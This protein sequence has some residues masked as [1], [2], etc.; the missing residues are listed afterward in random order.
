MSE[1]PFV[2]LIEAQLDPEAVRRLP[3]F[4]L[5]LTHGTR[6]VELP[7][8]FARREDHLARAQA[9]VRAHYARYLEHGPHRALPLVGYRYF[10]AP[11]WGFLLGLDGEVRGTF[12]GRPIE[13]GMVTKD[14]EELG[15]EL[16]GG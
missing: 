11:D 5:A 13:A 2:P 14:G 7:A 10:P 1:K 12:R 6:V 4:V 8:D 9:E 16:P 15:F 3:I